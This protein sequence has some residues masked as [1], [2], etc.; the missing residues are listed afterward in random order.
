MNDTGVELAQPA[1]LLLASR[2]F[3]VLATISQRAPGYPSTSLAPYALDHSGRPLFLLS[4][5]AVHTVNLLSDPRASLLVF[6]EAAETDPLNS[7]R[8]NLLGEIR[9][10]E[11]GE[12]TDART[13]YLTRHP[14]SE[15]WIDFGDFALYRM[16]VLE[17]Y[18]VGGFG[19]MGWIRG[20]VLLSP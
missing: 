9:A 2:S 3:G 7:A 15:R 16:T 1:R 17:A 8:L 5:L 13:A 12:M 20:P 6:D 19:V 10:I 14:G 11:V 18:Y 4:R